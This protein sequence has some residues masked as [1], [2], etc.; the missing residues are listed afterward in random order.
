LATDADAAKAKRGFQA[1]LLGYIRYDALRKTV[2]RFDLVVIGD[3]WGGATYTGA[4]RPGRTPLGIAFQ[5][6]SK[7]APSSAVAPQGARDLEDYLGKNH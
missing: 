3:H 1:R 2:D 6:A 7:D 4:P 5:L